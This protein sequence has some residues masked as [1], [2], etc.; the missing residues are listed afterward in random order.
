MKKITFI[1]LLS[2]FAAFAQTENIVTTDGFKTAVHQA[3][4][5]KITFMP[6]NIPLENYTEKDFL[7]TFELKR[8]ANLNIR[9][10][11]DNSITNYLHRLAP[12]LP[13]EVLTQ[14]GNYQFLFIVDGNLVYTE[15]LH[16]GAGLDKNT[17]TTFRVPLISTKNED[18]WSIYMWQR[19]MGNGGEKALTKG[20][21]NLKIEMRCWL[22]PEGEEQARIGALI[23]QGTIELIIKPEEATARQIAIQQIQPGSGWPVSKASYDKKI[24]KA[25]NEKIATD[26]FKS[27]TGIAV[28]KDGELLL[29]EYFNSAARNTLHDTRSVGKSFASVMMGM[30]IADGYIKD[31]NQTLDAFY[32]LKT[33]ANYSPKK[34]AVRIKDL[35]M[36]GSAFKGSDMDGNSPGNEENM[37]PTDNWVKFALDLPVDDAKTNGAQWDYF[38]AGVVVLGDIIDKS[39]PGGLDKYSAEKLFQPLGIQNYQWQYTP[40]KVASTAGGLQMPVLDFA[41]FGQLYKNNGAWNGKQLLPEKWIGQTFTKQLPVTGRDNEFYGFLF[42]NKTYTA[43][44]KTYEA[45]YCSGNGGNRIVIFQNLPLVIVITAKAY[46]KPYA[47]PQADKIIEEYLLKAVLQ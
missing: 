47:H 31:E 8:S 32:D 9:V 34:S 6:E 4:A 1:L 22:K 45:F 44:G 2:G 38:T 41:R 39:V 40:Q 46:N 19:F 26:A 35:L 5:G 25:L 27:I 20:R 42:W 16:P 13:H 7:A 29:E 36:M 10:F 21:H 33:Y 30:A 43:N 3:N 15:N 23:A 14:N 28:I 17:T 18:F 37:Y 12:E 11:M 24:I